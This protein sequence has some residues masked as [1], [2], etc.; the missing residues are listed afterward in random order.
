MAYFAAGV[1]TYCELPAAFLDT[2]AMRNSFYVPVNALMAFL[3]AVVSARERIATGRIAF[4]QWRLH[5][6]MAWHFNF[7]LASGT[8][9]QNGDA[10]L[11][12]L[13]VCCLIA[14]PCSNVMPAIEFEVLSH[15]DQNHASCWTFVAA[16]LGAVVSALQSSSAIIFAINNRMHVIRMTWSFASVSAI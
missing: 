9:L 10:T 11:I 13:R 15:I 5:V 1:R 12:E 2:L 6:K 4:V 3:A 16:A 8:F 14:W 7:M